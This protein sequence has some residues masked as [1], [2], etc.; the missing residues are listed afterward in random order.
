MAR[1]N[2]TTEDHLTG[3]GSAPGTASYMS[4]EQVR[5]KPLDARTDLFSL[6]VV[7]YEMAT[8]QMPFRGESLGDHFRFHSEQR[9]CASGTPESR[10]ARRIREHHQQVPGERSQ[11]ALPARFGDSHRPPASEAG[12][13]FGAAEGKRATQSPSGHRQILEGD[14]SCGRDFAGLLR[15]RLLLFSPPA[16]TYGQGHDRPRRFHKYDRRSGF[17]RHVA[18]RACPCNWNNRLS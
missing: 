11:P 1:P 14:R 9:S 17:R 13:R 15:C 2:V 10:S 5:A 3:P 4:P 16:K 6:G 7:L 12:Q 8:G 18:A